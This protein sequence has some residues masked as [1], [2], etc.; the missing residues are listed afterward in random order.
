MALAA[1]AAEAVPEQKGGTPGKWPPF[2]HRSTT[3]QTRSSNLHAMETDLNL[4][5]AL[6]TYLAFVH[7]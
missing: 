7:E 3:A 5:L 2:P 1:A 6:V 4:N